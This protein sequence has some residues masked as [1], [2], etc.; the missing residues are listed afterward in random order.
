M[1]EVQKNL[2]KI[3]KSK[4]LTLHQVEALSNGVHKVPVIGSYE[5]GNRTISVNKLIALAEFYEVS[6]TEF[7][8]VPA[9]EAPTRM[10]LVPMEDLMAMLAL[11]GQVVIFD[12]E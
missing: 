2:R 9:P 11:K 5:R 10:A 1:A 12:G 6:V 3:R 8:G 7:F 4:G